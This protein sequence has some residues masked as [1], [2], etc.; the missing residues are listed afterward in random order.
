MGVLYCQHTRSLSPF[1]GRVGRARGTIECGESMDSACPNCGRLNRQGARF[2]ASCQAPLGVERVPL[3]PGQTLDGGTYR[4]LR[5]LGKGGMGA[6]WLAANTKA[7]DRLCVIKEVIDY[8]DPLDPQERAKAQAR[9]RVEAETLAALRHPGIPDLYA[10]FSE[11][12]RNFLVMEYIEG[13]NL[14]KG[15][16]TED[17]VGSPMPIAE[18]I[19]VTMQICEVLEYLERQQPPVVHNDIK[20]ANIIIDQHSGRAVLV[21]FGTAR[22]R[23]VQGPDQQKQSVYGTVGYA[24]PEL[25]QG[26]SVPKSDVFALAA[27]AYH[28]LADDDPR[29]APFRFAEMPR[30]PPALVEVLQQ[31]L[32]S[33]L[34]D[35]LSASELRETLLGLVRAEDA[36]LRPLTFPSGDAAADRRTLI[37]LVAK[38]WDYATRILAD[39]SIATWLRQ[40]LHDPVA[41]QAAEAALASHPSDPG[42]A[43]DRFVRELDPAALPQPRLDLR[44]R[45]LNLGEVPGGEIAQAQLEIGNGGGG[46]L[47]GSLSTTVPWLRVGNG[48]RFGC[49]AGQTVRLPVVA[50]TS[51]LAPGSHHSGSIVVSMTGSQPATVPVQVRVPSPELSVAPD[52]LDLGRVRRTEPFTPRHTL[53]V[54]NQGASAADCRITGAP[55]WLQVHPAQFR[56][57][58]GARQ[59]VT[60]VGRM[61]KVPKGRRH[62]VR[63][64]VEAEGAPASQVR[65]SLQAG[66][67]AAG[68]AATRLA[69]ALLSLT[70]L[71]VLLGAAVVGW[72]AWQGRDTVKTDRVARLLDQGQVGDAVL[73]AGEVQSLPGEVRSR[74]AQA[75][76]T[77][78]QDIGGFYIDRFEVTNAQ[79]A[80]CVMEGRCRPPAA[81]S[82]DDGLAMH[83]VREVSWEQAVEYCD[84]AGKRLPTDAEW[85]E[86]AV[87]DSGWAYPWGDEL[88]PRQD[89]RGNFGTEAQRRA[90]ETGV[91]TAPVG[92]YPGGDSPYGVADMAGNVA[93][94]T[95][96]PGQLSGRYVYRGGGWSWADPLV[97]RRAEQWPDESD[98]WLGF[99][100]AQ[101]GTP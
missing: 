9:F 13:P 99:R 11:N 73:L 100:C 63:L 21:D 71:A 56:L 54:V 93:E 98:P 46:Y 38:H 25:Y 51:A 85:E 94:W 53:R 55:R 3:Q 12:G 97:G 69:R 28:L 61:S 4:I 74:L 64:Q 43:L 68:D 32:A 37:E 17:Q 75:L 30:L 16:S 27:T 81:W 42:A 78:M 101:G 95:R 26:E 22:M 62:T 44:T 29:D 87:G 47:F 31:A 88:D 65:V 41:A 90:A 45:E 39:G 86:A 15:L 19:Q 20:P 84:W 82:L 8:F 72:R 18:V 91:S 76:D 40:V 36:P 77:E 34:A 5:A 52:R 24:A 67:A 79:Y 70:L 96:T 60:V 6:V 48:G 7:F 10:Y 66:G 1:S 58:P 35:R 83:P 80:R 14:A 33:E 92:S 2:C 59:E 89:N 50:D 23:H 49:P 57:L